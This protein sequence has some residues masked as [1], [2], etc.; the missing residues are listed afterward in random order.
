METVEK[1]NAHEARAAE[2]A[3]DLQ[4]MKDDYYREAADTAKAQL[5]KVRR[6][7]EA[8]RAETYRHKTSVANKSERVC[9][10]AARV[11][12]TNREATVSRLKADSSRREKHYHEWHDS[13]EDTFINHPARAALG[14]V[15]SQTAALEERKAQHATEVTEA[16]RQKFK[17]GVAMEEHARQLQVR[18]GLATDR[19]SK[20]VP[21]KAQSLSKQYAETT[22]A[23][24]KQLADAEEAARE[25]ASTGKKPRTKPMRIPLLQPLSTKEAKKVLGIQSQ[26]CA[27]CKQTFLTH[28]L[29]GLVSRNAITKLRGK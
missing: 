23:V 22:K 20:A 27:L 8:V 4:T 21:S 14:R 17:F 16:R 6:K 15:V 28:N 5:S 11:C 29:V 1:A 19:T 2:T 24:E 3:A 13:N 12:A 18:S 9:E 26:P 7:G 10:R 25:M